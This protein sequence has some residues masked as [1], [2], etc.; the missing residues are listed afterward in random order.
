MVVVVIGFQGDGRQYYM[1]R[2]G[3]AGDR[4][5]SVIRRLSVPRMWAARGQNPG[6]PW[7]AFGP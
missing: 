1:Y 7:V 3:Q 5:Y 4:R 6:N 2:S